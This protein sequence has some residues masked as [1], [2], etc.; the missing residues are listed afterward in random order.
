M[1]QL[2]DVTISAD[3][4]GTFRTRLMAAFHTFERK[5]LFLFGLNSIVLSLIKFS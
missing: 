5:K 4:G 3:I 1:I 2:D